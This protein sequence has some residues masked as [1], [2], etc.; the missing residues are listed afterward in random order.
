MNSDF[1]LTIKIKPRCGRRVRSGHP[2]IFSNE[3]VPPRPHPQP[4][5]LVRVLDERDNFVGYATYNSHS[6][7]ALRL[8]SRYEKDFPCSVEWF[9]E[10]IRFA[11]MLRQRVYPKRKA[12]RLV[13]ADSDGIPGLIIDKYDTA[14]VMQILTAGMERLKETILEAL[15]AEMKPEAVFLRNDNEKRKLEGLDLYTEKVYGDVGNEVLIDENGV[16]LKINFEEGQKTGHFFDQ[17]DNREA[18][19]EFAHDAD[20][21]D[22]FSYT[23]AWSLKM[24]LSGARHAWAVDSSKEAIEQAKRNAEL[25]HF[26]ARMECI[27]E[28]AFQWLSKI[29]KANQKF[30]I[31]VVDPPAFAKSPKQLKQALRGYEDIN[32]QA[33][34]CVK[35]RGILCSCSCS[36][37]VNETQ[38]LESLQRAATRERAVIKV[39]QIRGQARDHPVLSSMPESRYLKCVI[40]VVESIE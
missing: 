14:Y 15:K 29:R 18:L 20:V 27:A 3:I 17:A 33:I 38:F 30:D 40:G 9:A 6:L 34:H 13:Y 35:N 31:V 1:G 2:W 4:G 16:Q 7:I 19:S 28:D 5:V 39:L 22:L 37:P 36:Y 25:N 12:Y 11:S 21:L 10:K 24:L 26:D 8:L 32:R 23:G